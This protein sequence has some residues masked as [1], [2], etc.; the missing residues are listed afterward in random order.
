ME[1]D[2]IIGIDAGLSGAIATGIDGKMEVFK[3]PK[4]TKEINE[5]LKQASSGGNTLV[6]IEFVQLRPS[7]MRSNRA[8]G[9]Q[10]LFK[11]YTT[12][13][14][15]LETIELDYVKVQ[16]HVWQKYLKLEKVSDYSQRKRNNKE[17]AIRYFPKRKITLQTADAILILV[18]AIKKL[19]RDKEWILNRIIRHG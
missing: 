5:L 6:V 11:N 9:L 4:S 12:I 16:P 15:L 18:F 10:K 7:D 2:R 19:Q 14:T 3:M 13:I 8:F 17:L 1:Y